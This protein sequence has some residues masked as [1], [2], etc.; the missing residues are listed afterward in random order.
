MLAA[1]PP[2]A[3]ESI[4][5]IGTFSVTNTY[6]NSTLTVLLFAVLAFLIRRKIKDVPRGLQNLFE[7]VTE[8]M[9]MYFDQ[10]TGSRKKSEKFLPL[11]GALFLYIVISNWISLL[12][13][14]GSI[15]LFRA[16]EFIPL[17]RPTNTDLNA[18]LSMAVFGVILA[19]IIGVFS[20]GFFK[21]F[22]KFIKLSDV[23]HAVKSKKAI[24]LMTAGIEFMVGFLEIISEAAKILSLSLRLFGNVFAGEVLLTVLGS[25]IAYFIPLPFMGLEFLVGIVQAAVFSMLVLTYITVATMPVGA[26]GKHEEKHGKEHSSEPEM[27]AV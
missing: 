25:I 9:L 23:W 18:T 12:P 26:H 27:S 3:A 13:G 17:F 11:I 7:W 5:N 8:M 6:I 19:H 22:N 24:N 15:G 21:Y 16:G 1:L 2:L 10:V 14:V 4:F 20:I